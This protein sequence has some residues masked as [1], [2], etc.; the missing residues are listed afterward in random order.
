MA[1][2]KLNPL[3][4]WTRQVMFAEGSKLI[5]GHGQRLDVTEISG[6]LWQSILPPSCIGSYRS[7]WYPQHDI[8]RQTIPGSKSDVIIM[9]QVLEHVFH[10]ESAVRNARASL[11][12][13][14]ALFVAT[15]F[16]IKV[17]DS[18]VDL[19]R[20]TELG[21]KTL[22]ASNGFDGKEILTGSWGNRACVTA[23]FDR[24]VHYD[25]LVHS[26]ENEREFPVMV[27]AFCR[28]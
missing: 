13:H 25:P 10:P 24:W 22:L 16:L 1:E 19:W 27:W 28:T 8:T 20:W 15:P 6:N 14:G 17:H 4:H 12:D 2:E 23:N 26:L 7:T 18:P 11:K 5:A 3:R 21:L 9:E